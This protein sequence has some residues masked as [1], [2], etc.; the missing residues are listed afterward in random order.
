MCLLLSFIMSGNMYYLFFIPKGHSDRHDHS[1]PHGFHRAS[2]KTGQLQKSETVAGAKI[3]LHDTVD[4]KDYMM[5]K[6]V[7]DLTAEQLQH[8]L[9]I[10]ETTC[11]G[12]GPS[13]DHK[14]R[15]KSSNSFFPNAYCWILA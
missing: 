10:V 9:N 8:I 13:E 11:N 12:Q 2:E 1:N 14:T 4:F 15:G 5:K 3:G 7:A 6:S